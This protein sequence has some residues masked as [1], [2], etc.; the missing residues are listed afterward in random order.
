[1]ELTDL[2][3]LIKSR[4]SIHKWKNKEVSVELLKQAVELAIWAPNS[5]GMQNWHFYI[6]VNRDTISAMADAVQANAVHVAS[7]LEADNLSEAAA[8]WREGAVRFRN[9]PAVIAVAADQ[10]FM[11]A[12]KTIMARAETDAKAKEIRDWRNAANSRVQSIAAAIMNMLLVFHQMG[13]G[14]LWMTGPMQGKGDIEKILKTPPGRDVLALVPVGYA[15]EDLAPKDRRPF[16]EVCDI[17]Q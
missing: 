16:D 2:A 7:W 8:K 3:N 6:I 12:D 10:Y 17:I 4:R 5:G 14:A 15:D 9:A 1:M 11:P 13:L